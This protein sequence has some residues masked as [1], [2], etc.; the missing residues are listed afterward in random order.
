MKRLKNIKGLLNRNPYLSRYFTDIKYRGIISLYQVLCI[1]LLYAGFKFIT[2]LMYEVAWFRAISVYYVILSIIRFI[3]LK[4]V[5]GTSK[6]KDRIE[7][8]IQGLRRYRICGY[9][10]FALNIA[11]AGMVIQMVWK[12]KGY[13]YPGI[14]I[15]ASA[16]YTFYCLVIAIINMIKF[17]KMDD[18]VLSAAKMLSF[19]GALMSILSLQ[20]AMLT[21]FGGNDAVFR[22]V[23][24]T[25]TG[26]GVMIVVFGMA[27]FMVIRANREL[28]RAEK[29]KINNS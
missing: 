14:I 27:V 11:M 22:Q 8:Y 2:S 7:I 1:D 6:Q 16:A 18:P 19:A 23:M 15:Y 21:Q 3:L 17:H 24:N 4:G 26:S 20:T 29:V 10:M 13:Q 5:R 25:A 28:K 9:L 12:N